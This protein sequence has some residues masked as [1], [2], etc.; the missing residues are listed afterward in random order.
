[1]QQS[2]K[3]V[4][5][6][7]V[8]SRLFFPA[9][10]PLA[11]LLGGTGRCRAPPVCSSQGSIVAPRSLAHSAGMAPAGQ[12]TGKTG[13]MSLLFASGHSSLSDKNGQASQ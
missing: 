2:E 5:V 7:L 4:D 6:V 8:A 12:G 3:K 13:K 9:S 10:R 1:M 11:V